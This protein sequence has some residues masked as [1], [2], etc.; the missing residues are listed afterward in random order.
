MEDVAGEAGCDMSTIKKFA[1]SS[2]IPIEKILIMAV[3]SD[4]IAYIMRK[5]DNS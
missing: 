1:L 2:K 3:D 4:G 5:D